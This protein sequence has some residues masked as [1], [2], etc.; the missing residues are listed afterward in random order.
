[1]R[2]EKRIPRILSL[3]EALWKQQPELRFHQLISNLQHVYSDENANYGKQQVR[4]L[5]ESGNWV[6][7]ACLDFFYLEDEKW[8]AFLQ[9]QLTKTNDNILWFHHVTDH[10]DCTHFYIDEENELLLSSLHLVNHKYYPVYYDNEE[11]DYYIVNESGK[12][13]YSIDIAVK[14]KMLKQRT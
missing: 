9:E 1:M 13:C 14:V 11:K 10:K 2:E 6:P 7:S 4:K 3:L 5:D 12:R 8:E